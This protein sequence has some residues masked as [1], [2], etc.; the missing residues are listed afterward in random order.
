MR[1][2]LNAGAEQMFFVGDF[3]GRDRSAAGA[4]AKSRADN[5]LP[6][7]VGHEAETEEPFCSAGR[8]KMA[9]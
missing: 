8:S 9:Q 7:T 4:S 2:L 5:E 3:K 1:E 6:Q